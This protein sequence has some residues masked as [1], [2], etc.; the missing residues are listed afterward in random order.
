MD[1]EQIVSEIERGK[2]HRDDVR[3]GEDVPEAL[4]HLLAP[5]INPPPVDPVP[6]EL[7]A[8]RALGLRDLALVVRED[9]VLPAGVNVDLLSEELR[10]HRA[11]LDMPPGEPRT[12]R[13]LPPEDVPGV[14]PDALLPERKVR[15]MFLVLLYVHARAGIERGQRVPGKPPVRRERFDA[16]VHAVLRLVRVS[17]YKKLLHERDHFRNGLGRPRPLRGFEQIQRAFVL[18]I[19][20]RVLA[21]DGQRVDLLRPRLFLHLVLALITIGDEM[22]DVRDVL[23]VRHHET[24]N[25]QPPPKQ[26]RHE[27][28]RV[29]PDVRPP[30]D[31]RAAGVHGHFFP[32]ERN[33]IF[34]L[35]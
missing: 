26:I 33:E 1:G 28:G 15:R 10:A 31:R 8:R 16:V 18:Q 6:H 22:P 30:V 19:L 14:P 29:V 23:H 17:L 9:V 2:P 34:L 5:H 11:A 21:G 12:P 24:G 20:V 7:P 25:L 3:D 4:A 35:L 13:R 27:E 32:I